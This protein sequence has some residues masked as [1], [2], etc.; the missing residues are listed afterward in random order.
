MKI[1]IFGPGQCGSTRL[2]NM[3]RLVFE[4]SNKDIKIFWIDDYQ[5]NKHVVNCLVKTHEINDVLQFN[6]YDYKLL[7]IR[8][9]RDSYIS[10]YKKDPKLV[11]ERIIN[12]SKY[13]F[14]FKDKSN[15]IIKYED[16]INETIKKVLKLL[17]IECDFNLIKD[18]SNKLNDIKESKDVI[19]KTDPNPIKT[20]NVSK[21]QIDF[22][23]KTLFTSRVGKYLM[24]LK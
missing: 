19:E 3:V 20:K 22:Y 23:N 5:I 1:L 18:I 14:N 17:K 24:T 13:F 8:D 10:K 2:F 15:L 7:P 6:N 12:E 11:H 16:N 9:L 21:D 4:L